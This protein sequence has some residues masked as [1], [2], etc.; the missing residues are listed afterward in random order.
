MDDK[1]QL[2]VVI[3]QQ[4]QVTHE[5][6]TMQP[7]VARRST[8]QETRNEFRDWLI[9]EVEDRLKIPKGRGMIAAVHRL[10]KTA[11]KP[12]KALVSQQQL[13][14]YFSGQNFPSPEKLK[15]L[16]EQLN[17]S[18]PPPHVARMVEIKHTPGAI[19]PLFV[20]LEDAWNMITNIAFREQLVAVARSFALASRGGRSDKSGSA[21]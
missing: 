5:S 2:T 7:M 20:Q 17:L 14:K 1:L 10:L 4:P 3:R 21:N 19:D 8:R 16:C 15:L 13:R 6:N 9:R 11:G 18:A 12:A